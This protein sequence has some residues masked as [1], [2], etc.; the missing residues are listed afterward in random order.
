MMLFRWIIGAPFAGLITV[1]LFLFMAH[2]IRDKPVDL[3]PA[4]DGPIIKITAPEPPDGP[5][6]IKP[7]SEVIPKEIPKTEFEYK[8]STT[9]TG[10][11]VRPNPTP[12]DPTPPGAGAL[13]GPTIRIAPP[14]PE[15]CRTRGIEGNVVVQFDVTP[16]GNVVNPRVISSPNACFARPILKAVSGWKYSPASG[17]GMRYG[18]VERFSFY[19]TD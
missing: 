8:K 15:N 13:G 19:L 7:P 11:I 16:E 1:S 17:G 4:V 18:V 3:P 14:Y 5:K 6:I 9:P 2:L 12:V 10:A